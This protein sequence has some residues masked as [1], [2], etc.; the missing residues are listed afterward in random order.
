MTSTTVWR[1]T[2][3]AMASEFATT[4]AGGVKRDYARRAAGA[5]HRLIDE[6][7]ASLS[8]F[9]HDSDV[10][11]LNSLR[12]REILRPTI[13]CMECLAIARRVWTETD[14]AFD[15]A[16]GALLAWKRENPGEDGPPTNVLDRSGMDKLLASESHNKLSITS[17]GLQI[18]LGAIG[19]GYGVDCAARLLR[20]VWDI[21]CAQIQGG[22][23]SMT[24]WG[25]GVEGLGWPLAIRAPVDQETILAEYDIHDYSVSGSGQ[26][27]HG[28]HIIN[29]RNG[30]AVRPG[31]AAWSCAPS[32]AE[33]DALSTALMIMSIE[34]AMAYFHHREDVGGLLIDEEGRLLEMGVWGKKGVLPRATP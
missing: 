7:E 11:R 25:G 15:P 12:E 6:V 20:E 31:H 26:L 17:A 5:A 9:R 19:K 29:P 23:S 30:R 34:E 1:Y 16:I 32:A 3:R 2:H 27:L 18:D 13:H 21:P 10:S 14:G 22:E 28:S 8:R 4:I 24:T 33:A